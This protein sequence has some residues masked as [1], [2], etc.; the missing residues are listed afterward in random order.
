MDAAMPA[1]PKLST[2]LEGPV[3]A[4]ARSTYLF[5]GIFIEVAEGCS[6]EEILAERA[7]ALQLASAVLDQWW[8]ALGL[9]AEP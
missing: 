8:T 2:E 6:V 7:E 5:R 4:L 9:E 1:I 3:R